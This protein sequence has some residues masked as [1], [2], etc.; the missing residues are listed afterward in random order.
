M[1]ELPSHPRETRD[2]FGQAG[3]EAAWQA[4]LSSGRLHH[5]WL[6]T[7]PRGVGKATFAY[8]A[9]ATLLSHPLIGTRPA[10][11]DGFRPLE[12]V[13]RMVAARAH[14]DLFALD[15]AADEDGKIPAQIAV[16]RV[17]RLQ[18]FFGH[19]AAAGGWRIAIVD[20]LDDLNTAGAN[21]L[22]KV[23]EEPPSRAI[24]FVLAHSRG[25]VL[26]TIRSRCR[27]LDFPV[28][29]SGAIAQALLAQAPDMEAAQLEAVAEAA[30][31]SMATAFE[32]L[33]KDRL[34][35]RGRILAAV[36]LLPTFD[37]A[38]LHN[39]ADLMGRD[40]G[41]LS[42]FVDLS[43]ARLSRELDRPGAAPARLARVAQV[44]DKLGEAGLEASVY[45][46]DVKPLLFQLFPL[47]SDALAPDERMPIR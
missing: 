32:L 38:S 41:A 10:P 35:L 45:N 8:R 17:R 29:S 6:L 12:T 40:D 3:A 14:P 33:D 24:F 20:A 42:M 46:L 43:R 19:T 26:P 34:A 44:W 47:M 11:A 4:A 28:L 2:L 39:L 23:L 13:E 5:A 36:E 27:R 31:G 16:E 30:E 1:T 21:A 25:R 37:P 22:L 18:G 9:A 15:R 7:G